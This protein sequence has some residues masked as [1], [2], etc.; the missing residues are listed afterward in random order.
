MEVSSLHKLLLQ[1]KTLS[2]A[3]SANDV[4]IVVIKRWKSANDV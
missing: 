1:A 2:L 3:H 4:S